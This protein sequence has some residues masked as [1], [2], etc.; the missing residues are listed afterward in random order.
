MKK[1]LVISLSFCFLLPVARSQEKPVHIISG[2]Y[3]NLPFDE[4]VKQVKEQHDIKIF[5]KSEW[6][7][8]ITVTAKGDSIQL[9]A[10]LD[11][12][13]SPKDLYF[14]VKGNR[15]VFITGNQKID[16]SFLRE[17]LTNRE[18]PDSA[19]TAD[20]RITGNISYEKRINRVRIGQVDEREASGKALLSGRVTSLSS[21]EPVI[22]ATLYIEGTNNGVITN[23][24]GFYALQVDAGSSITLNV[25]CLGMER[26]TYFVVVNSSGVL[27]IEMS[28]KLVDIQE[29]VVRSGK[30]E[31]VRGIQMG[32]QR[33]GI[34]EIKAIPVVLGERDILKVA[35]MLP[36]VQTVGEGAAGFNVRGSSSDQNLFLVNEIPVFNT[37]H[38][39]GFFSVFNPDI[40]GDFNLYKSNFPVEYGGR[41][42]SV[43]EVSTRKGNKKK[44]GARG[45][46]SPITGSLLVETPV[47][48]D[49][50]S[51]IFSGRSTYSD[52]ILNRVE[53]KDIQNSDASFYDLMTGIHM[54]PDEKS[55]LQIFGYYSKDK[56]SL[57]GT[58]DY[59]YENR[60]ASIMY[61]RQLNERWKLDL[62]GVIS[63]YRNYQAN[64]DIVTSSYE[65]EFIVN[66]KELK[67]KIT[68]FRFNN[69][70]ISSGGNVIFHN[71]NHGIYRPLG[72]ESLI[73]PNNFGKEKGIEYAFF[74]SDE[75]RITD[76]LRL[77]GGLRYSSFNYLGPKDIYT[78]ADGLPRELT[79]ITDTTSYAKSKSVVNY[80]GPEYRLSLNY[81]FY[82]DFSL[83]VSLN[84][85]RQYLFMLSNTVA[86]SPTDDWKLVDP[87]IIPPVAD[88]VS[89]GLYKNFNKSAL[90]TSA[91]FYYK[92]T[93]NI[94]EYKDGADL[95]LNPYFETTILQGNQNSWGAEF[96]VRRNAGRFT[97][98]M[99]YTYSRS[100]ITVDS[101]D[102]WDQINNG[103]TYAA[104]YDKPHS[105]NFICNY[106]FS[107]RFSLA[108]NMVYS[109]GRPITYPTGIF[110]IDGIEGISYSNRNEYRIPDYFRIDISIN[111]EG[112]L[113]KR[114]LAH[115]SW[116]F[117]VYNVT[118][119]RN[120]YSIY[121]KNENGKINGYK[122]SI[123]GMPI[124]TISYNFKLGNYAV[125]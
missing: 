45:G 28:E 68:G 7:E 101:K 78:Y 62:A 80:N 13:L 4:F 48:N 43:F 34:K 114:K 72:N 108:S 70:K 116:M 71:L 40:V 24:E 109:T 73:S 59:R 61:N 36:G 35:K 77:Y 51:L 22:G 53:D 103:I 93:R 32:F 47:V 95:T 92:K 113:L 57:A 74:L 115:S 106:K 124:F 2:T 96:L 42:A 46:I 81:E 123:Y 31:N 41:L 84:R 91:E 79:Y 17:R 102:P 27:N 75:Y 29:V 82:T 98:W 8:N 21:G 76:K 100:L 38:L 30:H 44:F 125:E 16:D 39:F 90:E 37:G 1:L 122:Q 67:A 88:Q 56:F 107:R 5:Y 85:M 86:I 87:H 89:F 18:E 26:E 10:L 12:L 50:V 66:H 11:R 110:N 54:L 121:F 120:A 60:G 15:Q 64:R 3:N 14:Y 63:Q 58:N 105:L 55:S 117:A 6:I 52:W 94:V 20:N 69:H 9:V 97:G 112:N 111:L 104:N 119:R 99:S 25:S 23:S 33:I 118:G 49:K 65:H 83:K 19:V